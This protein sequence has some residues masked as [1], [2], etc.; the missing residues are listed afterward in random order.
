MGRAI[1]LLAVLVLGCGASERAPVRAPSVSDR[2]DA[3]ARDLFRRLTS[4]DL[5]MVNG[6][7]AGEAVVRDLFDPGFSEVVLDQRR[8]DSDGPA[9][10][11]RDWRPFVGARYAGFCARR[12]G[13]GAADLPGLV[14]GALAIGELTIA[15]RD[16]AGEWAGLVRDLVLTPD[17]YRLVRWSVESP[18]R[19]HFDLESW[20]CDFSRRPDH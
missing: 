1:P 17:G 8:M 9:R 5:E 20:T 18:R 7:R 14:D 2:L 15:G 13:A 3:L 10:I 6:L 4:G 12:V 19:E 11:I 16:A